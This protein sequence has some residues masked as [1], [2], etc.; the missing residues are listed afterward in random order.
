M[1]HKMPNIWTKDEIKYLHIKK[2][3]LNQQIYRLYL[4]L[5]NTWNNTWPCI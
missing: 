4:S 3:Q 2:Q 5:A 1:Q